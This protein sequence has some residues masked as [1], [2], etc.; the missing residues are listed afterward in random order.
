MKN[1]TLAKVA[2]VG[3]LTVGSQVVYADADISVQAVGTALQASAN[4]DLCVTVPQIL[5]FG[6][7][8]VGDNVA[9]LQWTIDNAAGAA[10]GNDTTYSGSSALP[11]TAPAPF[12]TT[13]TAA[14]SNDGGTGI[15]AGNQVDLPVF[16]FS[17]SGSNVLITSSI[18]AGPTGGGL[19]DLL[20]NATSGSTIPISSFTA[21]AAATAI[22]QPALANNSSSTATATAGIVNSTDTWTYS[23]TPA[24]I[25]AAGTYEAR[26]T[27]VAA[28]P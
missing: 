3:L 4:V 1:K 22:P 2:A 26:V 16:L 23:Y 14:V 12:S 5:I 9:K 11:F 28:T 21:G 25:P 6:V 17:N 8:A 15:A 7:G 10:I 13:A 24:S 19:P 27:Y 20:L 18:T